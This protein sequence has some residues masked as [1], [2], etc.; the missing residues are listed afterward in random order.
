MYGRSFKAPEYLLSVRYLDGE[1]LTPEDEKVV[2]DKLL[3]YH[4]H[5]QDKIGCGL[6][7]IMVS[8]FLIQ[9]LICNILFI[10]CIVGDSI[11]ECACLLF[12]SFA[13]IFID[14]IFMKN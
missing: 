8:F 11:R 13:F 1:R 6:D 4:P 9:I 3:A 12:N 10:F 2:V 5:A 14:R 7:S